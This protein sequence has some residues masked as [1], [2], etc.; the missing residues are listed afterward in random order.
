[1]MAAAVWI[2]VTLLVGFTVQLVIRRILSSE[3]DLR[4]LM[5]SKDFADA[6]SSEVMA[7][8]REI[9]A[10]KHAMQTVEHNTLRE[11]LRF[12][13]AQVELGIPVKQAAPQHSMM[14]RLFNSWHLAQHYGL[15]FGELSA[16]LVE[17]LESRVSHRA[18]AH[19]AMAGARFT[20]LVLLV[21]P[22]GAVAIGQS[23]GMNSARF[24]L[25]DPF[26]SVLLLIGVFLA[27]AGVW[28]TESLSVTALGGVG[29]RA[30]PAEDPLDVACLLDV[31][32][33]ALNSGLPTNQAWAVASREGSPET[34]LVTALLALGAGE[35]AWK[36]LEKHSMYGPVARQ[37]AQQSRAGTAL[38]QGSLK[39]ARRLRRIAKDQAVA[40][41]ERILVII[42]A[43]LTLCFLPAFILVGLIP[44]VVGLAGI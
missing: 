35:R 44:L 12:S 9:T 1:M 11:Q 30:G 7:G 31:F 22:A 32:A 38:S 17:D 20:V 39:H 14:A 2:A 23:M 10:A 40:N 36:T 26:G 29:G 37:A 41:A 24:L 42:A 15:S 34:T 33:A 16:F 8:A 19:S 28:W 18:T 6:M 13:I 25:F 27:C 4:V 3:Q 5:Q 43:P 21:L